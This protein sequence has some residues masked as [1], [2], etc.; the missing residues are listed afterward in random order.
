MLWT[1][2][3]DVA[4]D[5]LFN[6][7]K[8]HSGWGAMHFNAA[9]QREWFEGLLAERPLL[10]RKAGGGMRRVWE[11]FR[12]G[13]RNEPLDLTVYNLALAHHLG[14]HR[15]S[16]LDWA[17]LRTRLIP[18]HLTPDLFAAEEVRLDQRLDQRL[19]P[20]AQN[21]QLQESITVP[22][23]RVPQPPPHTQLPPVP[24]APGRRT[25]SKG[26]A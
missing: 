26:L 17:R 24:A 18:Q 12:P 16:A 2:G 22:T 19:P 25:F 21:Q 7:F 5:H 9:L 10:K 20:Q 8:L 6:R 13:D 11:K 15:W 14:L 4:K 3:T 23:S 1:V